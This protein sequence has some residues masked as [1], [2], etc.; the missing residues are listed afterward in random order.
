MHLG[1]PEGALPAGESIPS[2][3][4]SIIRKLT[5]Q[6]FIDDT[7]YAAA[8]VREK[9]T[10]SRWGSG[11]IRSGLRHETDQRGDHRRGRRGQLDGTRR[12][13]VNSKNNFAAKCAP[14]KLKTVTTCAP[15]SCVTERAWGSISAR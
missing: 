6:K 4:E 12:R 3:H 9:A 7:R 1:C 10:L 11:K 13:A 14:S 15:N 8:Y 2:A 5:E